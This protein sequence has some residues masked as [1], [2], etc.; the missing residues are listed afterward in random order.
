MHRMSGN[1][2]AFETERLKVPL[3]GDFCRWTS[4]TTRFVSITATAIALMVLSSPMGCARST[5]RITKSRTTQRTELMAS[6][7]DCTILTAGDELMVSGEGTPVPVQPIF[8]QVADDGRVTI[9]GHQVSVAGLTPEQAGEAIR[10]TFV[11]NY[12]SLIFRKVNV[13]K[14]QPDGA[15]NGS[16]PIRSETNRTS[17][18]AGSRR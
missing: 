5:Q 2:I 6:V 1:E 4:L 8:R 9:W 18:A 12:I 10:Q 11:T 17:L 13:L 16:Q 3:L 7:L 15:A 14:V